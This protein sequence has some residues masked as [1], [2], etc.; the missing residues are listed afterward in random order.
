M[1]TKGYTFLGWV[2][3][4]LGS[5]LMKRQLAENR[6]KLGAA[7]AVALVLVAGV[8]AARSGD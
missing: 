6:V 4:Q 3:W 7:G 5:R 2:V 8:A 1:T